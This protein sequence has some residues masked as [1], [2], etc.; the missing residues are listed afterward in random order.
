MFNHSFNVFLSLP[1]FAKRKFLSN[2]DDDGDGNTISYLKSIFSHDHQEPDVTNYRSL[3]LEYYYLAKRS[4]LEDQQANRLAQLL[5]IAY[6]D[7]TFSLLVSEVDEALFQAEYTANPEIAAHDD[8]QAAIV[9]EF[10]LSTDDTSSNHTVTSGEAISSTQNFLRFYQQ[11]NQKRASLPYNSCH[12]TFHSGGSTEKFKTRLAESLAPASFQAQSHYDIRSIKFNIHQNSF[13]KK[14]RAQP[15]PHKRRFSFYCWV[16]LAST[17]AIAA[18]FSTCDLLNH[19]N[20]NVLNLQQANSNI[21]ESQTII[22][23]ALHQPISD[24]TKQISIFM[25]EQKQIEAESEQMKAE[26]AQIE[27]EKNNKPA[28]AERWHNLAQQQKNK[29]QGYLQKINRENI[30]QLALSSTTENF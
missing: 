11:T 24:D 3:I 4:T 21:K 26:Q 10:V 9:K 18:F 15:F 7:S 25:L 19:T 14:L 28:D 17:F 23:V 29:A 13:N 2:D 8:N 1:R 20:S 12:Y 16:S 5:D 22:K 27:A 30:K 6:T